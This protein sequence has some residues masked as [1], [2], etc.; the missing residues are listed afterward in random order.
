MPIIPIDSV[1]DPRIAVFRDL[2]LAFAK[3]RQFLFVVEGLRLTERLL[4]SG[5]RVNSVLAEQRYVEQLQGQ[6]PKDAPLYVIKPNMI[7]EVAGFEFHR[8]VLGCGHRPS[9]PHLPSLMESA[10]PRTTIVVCVDIQDLQNLGSII[11]S[12]AAF[13]VQ[14]VLLSPSC[15]DPFSRRVSR[16]SMGANLI[17]PLVKSRDL[18]AD[19]L[20]LRHDFDMQLVATVLDEQ[21]SPLVAVEPSERTVLLLGSEWTGLKPQWVE[22]CDHRVSIPMAR[23]VDSLNV[24]VA[25]GIFLH[26]FTR[27]NQDCAQQGNSSTPREGNPKR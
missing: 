17:V 24:S 6:M 7:R 22:M 23:V 3:R 19:L 12:S 16:T 9:Q 18:K 4:A 1:E 5:L 11:R 21:A 20:S 2:K 8:G 25:A 10:S 13:G 14:A 15:A 26:H 27:P